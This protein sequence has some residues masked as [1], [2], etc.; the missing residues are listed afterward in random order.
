[1]D[2]LSQQTRGYS[3]RKNISPIYFYPLCKSAILHWATF[4]IT[5]FPLTPKPTKMGWCKTH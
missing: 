4:P 5:M 1:M 2:F 3:S